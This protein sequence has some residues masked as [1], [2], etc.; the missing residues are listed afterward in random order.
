MADRESDSKD[1][2]L[3]ERALRQDNGAFRQIVKDNQRLVFT[4]V[5]KMLNNS[6]DNKDV[7]QDIFIKVWSNLSRFNYNAKLSTWIARIAYNT[8]I[9][10]LRKR[11]I[12]LLGDVIK[13]R[14]EEDGE[15]SNP[16]DLIKDVNSTPP[17]DVLYTLELKCSMEAE[18]EMLPPLYRTIIMLY[19]NE[20]KSYEEI[21]SIVGLPMGTVKNYLFRARTKLKDSILKKYKKEDLL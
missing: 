3:V 13:N 18:I 1:K 9:N 16:M 6:A 7:S 4:I 12:D 8:Y 2:Q 15:E 19:H 14:F 10:H 21:A 20:E 17:D 11:K 5:F